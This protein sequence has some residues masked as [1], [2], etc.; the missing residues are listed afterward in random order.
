MIRKYALVTGA[1]SG[2]GSAIAKKLASLNCNLIINYNKNISGAEETAQS[3]KEFGV[4]AIIAQGNVAS[5]QDC[6][7][8]INKAIDAWGK[9]DILVNNAGITKFPD[10]QN[11]S[12]LNINAFNEIYSVNVGGAFQMC[13]VAEQMLKE[14]K[15]SIVNISSHSGISGMGS[16]IAY[17]AS[18]GAL[19]TMTLGL[20]RAFSPDVRV[21]AICPGFVDTDWMSKKLDQKELQKFKKKV[22]EISPL[23][24][25]VSAEDVA[26]ATS[27][28]ALGGNLITGQLLVIDGGVHLTINSP[29]L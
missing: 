21:N 12:S 26:E 1:S 10:T 27:W 28:F 17:A 14:A 9:I 7:S 6:C 3:C 18:K 29:I 2:I 5:Y 20:A 16:S 24:E 25:I 22:S 11:L 15:G 4:E 13:S 23:Q 19:N 8:I